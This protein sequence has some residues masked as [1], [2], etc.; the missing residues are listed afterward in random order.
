MDGS[1]GYKI[2]PMKINEALY[3]AGCHAEE[4]LLLIVKIV[5]K[6]LTMAKAG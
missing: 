6:L 5:E 3:Q 4:K 1:C 2:Q